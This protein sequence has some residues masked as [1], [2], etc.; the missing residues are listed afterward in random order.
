[1]TA[2]PNL[3][4]CFAKILGGPISDMATCVSAKNRVKIFTIISQGT[5]ALSFVCLALVPPS[6]VLLAQ[7]AYTAAVAFS[8]LMW[9]GPVK[10]AA[11]VAR[12]HS[13]FIFAVMSFINSAVILILPPFVNTL[14]PNNTSQQWAVILYSICGSVVVCTAMF[15]FVGEAE[16]AWW[17][18]PDAKHH[19][20]HH[21]NAVHEQVGSGAPC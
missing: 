5:M 9:V 18:E 17:T 16:L 21:R 6:M 15:A 20:A 3:V 1:M 10:R 8:G 14:A 7:V 4:S 19:H 13:H 2:F 11:L 12:Q